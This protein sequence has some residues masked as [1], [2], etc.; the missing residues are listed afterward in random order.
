MGQRELKAFTLMSIMMLAPLAGCFGEEMERDAGDGVLLVESEGALLAGM[1][2][3][4]SLT[5]KEDLAVYIPYF[6]QDPGSLRAQNGTVLDLRA[7]ENIGINILLPPRN[8]QVAFFLGEMGRVN[9][10]VREADV[11]WI[12]WL[13]KPEGGSAVEAV[14]NQDEN[15]AWPWL[16][17]GLSLIH[18]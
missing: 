9:W 11:S 15:G 13:N 18:I 14:A 10:P 6:V 4:L 7:G 2:Q 16:V 3:Q 17:P 8:T 1:W 12:S 5:A